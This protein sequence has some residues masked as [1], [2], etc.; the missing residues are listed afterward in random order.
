MARKAAKRNLA[1]TPVTFSIKSL[2][3]EI[4]SILTRLQ[5]VRTSPAKA[6]LKRKMMA[7]QL[8]VYCGEDMSFDL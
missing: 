7:I 4:E 6:E 2:N 1:N 5:S 3:T 8:L